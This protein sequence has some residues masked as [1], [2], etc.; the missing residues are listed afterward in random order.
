MLDAAVIAASTAPLLAFGA[1]T[2]RRQLMP[3]M[4]TWKSLTV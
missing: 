4:L 1:A 2:L 3:A